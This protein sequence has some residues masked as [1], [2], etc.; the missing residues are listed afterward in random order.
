VE[1]LTELYV[2]RLADSCTIPVS[3]RFGQ[4]GIFAFRNN[5]MV[6]EP[7]DTSQR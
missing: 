5:S 2:N 7:M 3:S 6:Y 1:D 4:E